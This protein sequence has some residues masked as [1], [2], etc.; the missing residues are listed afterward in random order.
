MY[1]WCVIIS[2]LNSERHKTNLSTALLAFTFPPALSSMLVPTSTP[3]FAVS[4]VH[5]EMSFSTAFTHFF[6]CQVVDFKNPMAHIWMSHVACNGFQHRVWI[7]SH[8]LSFS[9]LFGGRGGVGRSHVNDIYGYI[10]I[11]IYID[12]IAYDIYMDM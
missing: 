10:N 9:L 11:Y 1:V 7:V 6:C 2:K 8:E 3:S 4:I 12:I 5:F